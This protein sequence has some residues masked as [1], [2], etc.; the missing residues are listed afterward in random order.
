MVS[1]ICSSGIK[2]FIAEV[3]GEVALVL[4][5]VGAVGTGIW[6]LSCVGSYMQLQVTL[7]SA[8]V[9]AEMTGKGLLPCVSPQVHHEFLA[10]VKSLRAVGAG[11]CSL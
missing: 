1:F 4:G 11:V 5:A 6:L 2:V 9:G 7:L 10:A 8:A 3:C